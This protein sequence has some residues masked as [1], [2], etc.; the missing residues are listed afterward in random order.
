MI[1]SNYIQKEYHEKKLYYAAV[2]DARFD[3]EHD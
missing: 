1:S 3:I 2:F